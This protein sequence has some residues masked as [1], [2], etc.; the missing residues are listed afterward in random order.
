MGSYL[1]STYKSEYVEGFRRW[2]EY[3]LASQ[4]KPDLHGSCCLA[5]HSSL[6]NR[7][8]QNSSKLR[9]TVCDAF[10]SRLVLKG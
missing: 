10:I 4:R 9:H 3:I 2:R 7:S 8:E 1:V 5:S 6:S